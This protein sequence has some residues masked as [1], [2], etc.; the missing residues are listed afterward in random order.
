MDGSLD[1]AGLFPPANLDM[2]PTVANYAEHRDCADGWMVSRLVVPVSRLDEFE[3]HAATLLP[4]S[5]NPADDDC[6]VISALTAPAGEDRFA[7]DLDTIDAFNERHLAPGTGAAV[8]D[9]IECRASNA[10]EIDNA[11]EQLPESIFPYFELDHH[12][13]IR[14][15]VAAMAGM[16]AGAKIR[17]GGI[18]ADLHPTPEELARFIMT[19]STAEV[20]FK[21]TAGLHHPFR[22]HAES[23]GCEQFGFLNVFV[24]SCLAWW[25]DELTE[26]DL[27]GLLV[28]PSLD[29]FVFQDDRLGCP[30]HEIGLEQIEEARERFFHGFGS[31]SF[32]EPLEDLVKLELLRPD[33]AAT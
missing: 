18:T 26:A 21:A 7:D 11:L 20:P 24:G 8:I 2:G 25:G 1:Y 22:H 6:W 16:D 23:V 27:A 3:E 10:A 4:V 19:C 14:G 31:C 28:A 17:T 15:L 33:A 32:L 9:T 12:T 13:D 30:G 5:R 29:G